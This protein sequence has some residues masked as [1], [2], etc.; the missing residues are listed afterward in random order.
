L[1]TP[2]G[3]AALSLV[4]DNGDALPKI[5]SQCHRF[6]SGGRDAMSCTLWAQGTGL[7]LTTPTPL[8]RAMAT[9][10]AVPAWPVVLLIAVGV[11]VWL[12]LRKRPSTSVRAGRAW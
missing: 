6:V 12:V 7:P 5:L 10:A 2:A 11:G 8:D 4:R 1:T 3:R 9:I